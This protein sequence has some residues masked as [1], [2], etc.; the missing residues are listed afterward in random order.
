MIAAPNLSGDAIVH[1][2]TVL[3]RVRSG[4][5]DGAGITLHVYVSGAAW[6]CDLV[7]DCDRE[8]A[9]VTAKRFE[10]AIAGLA[11]AITEEG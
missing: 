7:D 5:P 11:A 4:Q 9:C 6:S 2:V 8:I 3:G 10:T 1:L